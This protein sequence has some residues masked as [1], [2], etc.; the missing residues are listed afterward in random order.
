MHTGYRAT[1]EDSEDL[2]WF[3]ANRIR[4]IKIL[5]GATDTNYRASIR[6]T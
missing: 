4:K 5:G 6:A 1:L 2:E 3:P